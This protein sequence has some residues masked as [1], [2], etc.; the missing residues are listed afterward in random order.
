MS[1]LLFC[2]V[3]Y[4]PNSV[5]EFW[6]YVFAVIS[7]HF[8]GH[9][10]IIH[11]PLFH[12]SFYIKIH[13]LLWMTEQA[14]AVLFP[15]LSHPV[16]RFDDI[17]FTYHGSR[18]KVLD[19]WRFE[20]NPYYNKAR[21]LPKGTGKSKILKLLCSLYQPD[22]GCITYNGFDILSLGHSHLYNNLSVVFQ[23]YF[24]Y[25]LMLREIVALGSLDRLHD[26][27]L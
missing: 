19:Y 5:H 27:A 25:S 8:R 20:L 12:F 26:D 15:N 10:W 23:D 21:A 7:F 9:T 17:G 6:S 2:R 1:L 4:Y 13:H 3:F 14:E 16:I 22:E 18:H 24:N 11:S